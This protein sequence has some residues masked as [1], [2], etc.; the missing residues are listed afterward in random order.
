M[1]NAHF[2]QPERRLEGPAKVSGAARYTADSAPPGTLLARFVTSPYPHARIRS[3]DTSAA[4]RAPGV[5]AVLTGQDLGGARFGRN[6][7]DWPILATDVVRFIGERVVALAAETQE[8][9]E[10]ALALVVVEYEELPALFDPRCA[11][12]ADAPILHPHAEGYRTL[13][14]PRAPL[15]HA[16]LQGQLLLTHGD[17][18]IEQVLAGADLVVESEFLTP[19]Q[20][21]GFLEPHAALVWLDPAGVHVVSTNKAP[22]SLRQ[23]MA[24]ALDLPAETLIVDNT[25]IG[26]DFGGKGLSI[27]EFVCYHL[28]RRSGRPVASVLAYADELAGTNTRHA[29]RMRLRTG[30]SREGRILGHAAELL[31]DG[32]AYAA[33][34]PHR[35]LILHGAL[36]TL[37]AYAVPNA[38]FEMSV[39]YTNSV[40]GGHMR[41][42]GE[43]QAVFAGE[44]H[45]DLIAEQLGM[46]ALELRRRNVL[47]AGQVNAEGTAF[48]D[49]AGARVLEAAGEAVR[50][51]APRPPGRGVGLALYQRSAGV[52]KAA[53]ILRALPEGTFELLTGV[54]DQGGGSHTMVRRVAASVLGVAEGQ[55][56]VVHGTTGVARF[57]SGVGGSRV[58]RVLGEAVRQA[59]AAL[60]D[61]LSGGEQ[62]AWPVEVI[63]EREATHSD[64]G[65]SFAALAVEVEVD[66]ETGTFRLTDAVLVVDVGQI[67]NPVAHR[68]QLE[69]GFVFGLGAAL[70]EE[71]PVEEGQVLAG[72][73]GDYKLPTIADVPPL[74]IVEITS[75]TGPGPFGAKAVGE[76]SNC[77]VPPAIA[78][79]LAAAT[80]VRLRALPLTA[81]A[82]YRGAHPDV[83]RTGPAGSSEPGR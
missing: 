55:V 62:L 18:D 69:G 61:K 39:V 63:G 6:L 12:A 38:R 76:L 68:G 81:E 8:Q 9:A 35:D 44:S 73:L 57:D 7:M 77:G 51:G 3:I 29:A 4:A 59:A 58:T 30:V 82:L 79:A 47:R 21:H 10:A 34:K 48:A 50:W 52:G 46:D 83:E 13:R 45:L 74:R 42:P 65:T 23:Q 31:F 37:S 53:V 2:G 11:T 19:R 80:G 26:G 27:D 20:H 60:R 36:A 32:G 15:P 66:A 24:A 14:A 16:N 64:D 33:A 22:F 54:P 67:I 17:V 25:Y 75:P 70:M 41:S 71:L 40:P 28:A 43:V 72:S 49:P 78:N 5:H 56:S 1:S